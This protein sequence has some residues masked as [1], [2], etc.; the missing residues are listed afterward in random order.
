MP[1]ISSFLVILSTVLL[2]FLLFRQFFKK[3]SVEFITI[4][5][6]LSL[7]CSGLIL[8]Y[9]GVEIL[10]VD[11]VS[12]S[13][14]M[15]IS[16][17]FFWYKDEKIKPEVKTIKRL[18]S[19]VDQI[20]KNKGKL[21]ILIKENS[22]LEE[23]FYLKIEYEKGNANNQEFQ[24]RYKNFYKMHISGFT[25]E[26]YKKYFELLKNGETD[27]RKILKELSLI[28]DKNG[29]NTVQL[30]FASKLIHTVDS[31]F[32]LYNS[33]VAK[34]LNLISKSGSV[35]ERIESSLSV[36][37]ELKSYYGALS[38]RKRIRSV[39]NHFRER[40]NFKEGIL[41]DVKILDLLIK[42][43]EEL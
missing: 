29:D 12:F 8:N 38:S 21:F 13:I 31:G 1:I 43:K 27:L 37:E 10:P 36:Y 2:S 3:L 41:S 34:E 20:Y 24:K 5:V 23:Y 26:L 25:E 11:F 9:A 35:K 30:A 40:F 17:L 18:E 14:A 22:N 39:A 19:L 42:Q 6:F 15:L 4:V 33:V 7:S 28:K 32:P 16:Y